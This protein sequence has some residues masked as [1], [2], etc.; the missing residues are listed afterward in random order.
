MLTK[1][2]ISRT[3]LQTFF[4]YWVFVSFRFQQKLQTSYSGLS[5]NSQ[6]LCFD[7]QPC[8][9]PQPVSPPVLWWRALLG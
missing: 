5:S 7:R 2:L 8:L 3:R 4:S 9:F 6:I 1:V